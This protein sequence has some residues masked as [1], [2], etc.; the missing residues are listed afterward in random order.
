MKFYLYT[1]TR[2]EKKMNWVTDA[3]EDTEVV[4]ETKVLDDCSDNLCIGATGNNGKYYQFD[5]Y[6]GWYAASFFEQEF[7]L[8]G[9]KVTSK[10]INIPAEILI[11]YQ[12]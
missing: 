7:H 6:E 8:H 3:Y 2:L 5:S 10:E 1:L 4:V 11:S 12:V 9:L